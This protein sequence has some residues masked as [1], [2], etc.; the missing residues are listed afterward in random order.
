MIKLNKKNLDQKIQ[1]HL[2]IKINSK[3]RIK[4]LTLFYKKKKKKVIHKYLGKTAKQSI[5]N[6]L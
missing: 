2:W 6:S 3:K 5:K 1:S 4:R